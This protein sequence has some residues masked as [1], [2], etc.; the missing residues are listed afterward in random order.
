MSCK[1]II[2]S[3]AL[4]CIYSAAQAQLLN[5]NW[6]GNAGVT[7]WMEW[8]KDH[9]Y[10]ITSSRSD[11]TLYV[12]V[13]VH[14]IGTDQGT[15][16]FPFDKAVRA[17]CRMNELY[18]DA[19]IQF[20][21]VPGDPVR[22]INNSDW[23]EHDYWPGGAEMIDQNKIPGRLNAFVVGDPAGN[24]GYAW[25]DAIVLG[26][27]C[28]SENNTTWSHEAGHH[29]SLPHPFSGWEGTDWDYSQP[30]PN[31]VGNKEVERTDGS[32]CENAG[33]F[34]C[35]TPPDYLNY[36]WQCTDEH[37][38]EQL[39]HDPNNVSFRSDATLIM[40]YASDV[41]ASRFSPEQIAA[42]R[43][44]LQTE[45]DS[46][47]QVSEPGIGVDDEL[48]AELVSPID[49]HIVQYNNFELV[50]NPVP[51]ATIYVVEVFLTPSMSV[52][53]RLF[54]KTLYN[55]TSVTVTQAM[56]NNRTLYWRVRTYNEWDVCNPNDNTQLGIL[57][58]RNISATNEL[59]RTV[60][61]ELAPNP[62]AGGAPAKLLLESDDNMNA[63]LTVTDAAGRV[64]QQQ[65]LRL[66]FGEN[67][68]DIP[69]AELQSG[70]YIVTIQN[71]RGALIKRMAVTE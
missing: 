20:Y 3:V 23:Y 57:K 12:P 16:L 15:N 13:T 52:I 34:F 22:F 6:C 10:E 56:P 9:R 2:L 38:S 45:H 50:W 64:C 17:I 61:A 41:C 58:T 55:E 8:Y 43:A 30:A 7:P 46:Y 42:M 37:E 47:L 54:Y 44:N 25:R 19:N 51:N 35:D 66:Y 71:E 69:T 32:N 18:T 67:Q 63:L 29:L 59:E 24:C 36:R 49:S 27:G 70:L 48:A 26:T 65:K 1:Q 14:I 5:N 21:L 40:G 53:N 4:F 31:T 39:Q 11:E 33:D 68:I 28:S 62:V 60:I